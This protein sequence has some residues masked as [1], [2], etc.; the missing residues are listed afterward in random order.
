MSLF[1]LILAQ[2]RGYYD[3][4]DEIKSDSP[5]NSS[6]DSGFYGIFIGIAVLVL[7]GLVSF[8]F[9]VIREK[10]EAKEK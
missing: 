3:V 4:M 1:Q 2:S 10:R 6:G 9:G 7:I 8:A 5:S